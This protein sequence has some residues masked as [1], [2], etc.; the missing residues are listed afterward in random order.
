MFAYQLSDNA[1][2][3]KLCRVLSISDVGVWAANVG[4]HAA[5]HQTVFDTSY[6]VS[7]PTLQTEKLKRAADIKLHL[8]GLKEKLLELMT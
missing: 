4:M 5:S 3:L 8:G 2:L 1:M 7:L 6:S